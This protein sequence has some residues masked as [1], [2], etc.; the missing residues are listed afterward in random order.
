[1]I[2]RLSY[3][4]MKTAGF[5]TKPLYDNEINWLDLGET[6]TWYD[7]CLTTLSR[8]PVYSTVSHSILALMVL[9]SVPEFVYEKLK[10]K[11]CP[12]VT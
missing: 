5:T 3:F 8:T 4:H 7:C 2:F 9:V 10:T 1:M 12:S 11:S 6:G